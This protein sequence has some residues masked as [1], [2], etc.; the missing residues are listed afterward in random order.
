MKAHEKRARELRARIDEANYRYHVLDDPQISDADYDALLRELLDL[1]EAHAEVRTPDS[2]T[3]RVGGAPASGFP[4]YIHVRPMLSL[5]N[6]FD[7]SELLAFDARVRKL[8]G[9]DGD[10]AYTCELKIDG[11]AVSLRYDEGRL[12]AGGTRGG[13]Q[14]GLHRLLT[15]QPRKHSGHHW[16]Q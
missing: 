3:Q 7:E 5:A 14:F 16:Q 8:G 15:Y 1:E 9:V 4:E 2:P 10:V 6:A 12:T 13:Q 11:L